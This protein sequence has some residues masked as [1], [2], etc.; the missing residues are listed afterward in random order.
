MSLKFVVLSSSG[1]V[2]VVAS[3]GSGGSLELRLGGP[4]GI[5]VGTCRVPVTGGWQ[6]W[7]T[8]SC[9][10]AGAT[11][12]KDLFVKFTGG[13]GYLFNVDWWQFAR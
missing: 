9:P 5:L 4:T 1:V 2:G 12:T 11:G 3:A 13:S 7:T 10:I 6:T 8:V